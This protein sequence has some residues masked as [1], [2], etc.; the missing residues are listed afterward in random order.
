M[1]EK[2]ITMA[3][4]MTGSSFF[5]F[6]TMMTRTKLELRL[7]I[8]MTIIASKQPRFEP[9]CVLHLGRCLP[10]R[11]EAQTQWSCS[12]A[13]AL[14]IQSHFNWE[15]LIHLSWYG[16]HLVLVHL[17]CNMK[18]IYE[19]RKTPQLHQGWNTAMHLTPVH[20]YLSMKSAGQENFYLFNLV[21][22]QRLPQ[23]IISNS[24]WL[25][26]KFSF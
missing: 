6:I 9:I 21:Y 13:L 24:M 14:H 10:P 25:A 1:V 20:L 2:I 26:Q 3:V 8:I 12:K 22:H 23:Q 7:R 11:P 17:F 18:K 5:V 4:V 19:Q 15:I 16:N